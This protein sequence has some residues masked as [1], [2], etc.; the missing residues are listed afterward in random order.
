MTI[1]SMQHVAVDIRL[2]VYHFF[3]VQW[4]VPSM[5]ASQSK[6]GPMLLPNIVISQQAPHC[7]RLTSVSAASMVIV[8]NVISENA[9][10]N[11]R[12]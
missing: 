7:A 8:R 6:A 12:R 4:H 10:I 3:W 9:R 5:Q 1:L 11:A 2:S